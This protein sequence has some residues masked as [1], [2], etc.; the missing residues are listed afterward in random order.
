MANLGDWL[1]SRS[2]PSP[3]LSDG[4]ANPRPRSTP[5][6]EQ[7]A[8]LLFSTKHGLAE[9]GSYFMSTNPTIGTA[10]AGAVSA[11]FVD[12][13][14]FFVIQNTGPAGGVM[15]F[16]DFLRMRPTVAPASATN[17]LYA[18]KL[19]PS[20]LR[21]P[22]AGNATITP[23][24]TNGQSAT[25]ALCR[26]QA[27]TGAANLTVAAATTNARI[28]GNGVI[29]GVIPVVNDE[30][31]ISFGST[32][33]AS[34]AAGPTATASRRSAAA[35]PIAIPGGGSLTI[36]MWGLSNAATGISAEYEFGHWER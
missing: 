6:G 36:A 5:Y 29:S 18:L 15:V 12:T 2:R 31:V 7:Y 35:G 22:S 24:N 11:T 20:S 16:P 10:V 8:Q 1:A 17:W 32:D 4:T 13:V 30:L 21:T 33:P 3:A 28:L 26:L 9:E 25:A 23:V 27:F 14:A 19:E 34:S